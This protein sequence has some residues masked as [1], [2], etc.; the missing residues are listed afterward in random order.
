[1]NG[2]IRGP[3]LAGGPGGLGCLF[4]WLSGRRRTMELFH[5]VAKP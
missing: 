3:Q 2:F 1:M 5:L 4:R